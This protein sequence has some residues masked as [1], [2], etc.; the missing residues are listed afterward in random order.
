M[1]EIINEKTPCGGA[2]AK[3]FYKDSKGQPVSR[4]KACQAHI[5]EYSEDGRLLQETIA[6]VN[7]WYP[8]KEAHNDLQ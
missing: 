3:I 7:G 8:G 6:F 2:Y 4:D 5:H 1:V